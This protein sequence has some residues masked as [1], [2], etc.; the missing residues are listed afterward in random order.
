MTWKRS[1]S[2]YTCQ[3]N[4]GS[5]YTADEVDF[6]RAMDRYKVQTHRTHPDC[7]DVLRV[8]Y[9]LGYRRVAPPEREAAHAVAGN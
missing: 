3:Q 2:G 5:E 8:L 4:I 9:A 7:R 1:R 6:L